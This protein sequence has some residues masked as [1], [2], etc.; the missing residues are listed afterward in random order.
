MAGRD[1]SLEAL[2]VSLLESPWNKDLHRLA[3]HLVCRIA[4]HRL[5]GS[6]PEDDT[7]RCG[8]GDHD[9]VANVVEEKTDT[10]LLAAH[11]FPLVVLTGTNVCVQHCG[12]GS[13][14]DL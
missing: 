2:A 8:I 10:E 7:P 5:G 6:V 4:K 1:I 13:N 9:A 12:S 11:S 3:D 14:A